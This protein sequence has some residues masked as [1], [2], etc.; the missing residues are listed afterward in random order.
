MLQNIINSGAIE[1]ENLWFVTLHPFDDGNGRIT[2]A[3]T[4]LVLAQGEQQSIRF[5]AMSAAILADRKGYHQHLESAQKL[6]M[7]N[8]KAITTI[9]DG[10]FAT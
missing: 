2:R 6:A 1:G 9:D 5:Y 3:L 8:R 4:D 10:N 7:F